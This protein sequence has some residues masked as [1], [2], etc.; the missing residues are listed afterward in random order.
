MNSLESQ[1]LQ[2]ARPLFGKK[3]ES[4]L[5]KRHLKEFGSVLATCFK[6]KTD[7]NQQFRVQ[8]AVVVHFVST[9]DVTFDHLTCAQ[10]YLHSL[11]LK[12]YTVCVC[13]KL[14]H[15]AAVLPNAARKLSEKHHS[16][17]YGG[18]IIPLHLW[19]FVVPK[20]GP[21]IGQGGSFRNK[22]LQK[23]DPASVLK[24]RL[25]SQFLPCLLALKFAT[26]ALLENI[27]V[28]HH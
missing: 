24:V 6:A 9:F 4:G 14:K 21:K 7:E 20:T 8:E 25:I 27:Q 18:P 2:F 26:H 12:L 10:S 23:I 5:V 22:G 17:S 1:I 16:R 11:S 13:V 19:R 28:S 15:V 3:T